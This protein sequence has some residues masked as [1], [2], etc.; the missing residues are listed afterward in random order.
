MAIENSDVGSIEQT[1]QVWQD[2]IEERVRRV[3]TG[4]MARILKMARKPSKQEFRQ[5]VIVCGIGMF[6][7]GAI[8]FAMLVLMDNW[9]PS[10]FDWL[11]AP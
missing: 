7:L 10:F 9:L 5:T 11:T 8:G 4:S 2:G 3:Q 6:I 1:V